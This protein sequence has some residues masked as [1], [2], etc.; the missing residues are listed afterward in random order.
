M[1]AS[2]LLP[3]RAVEVRYGTFAT[4]CGS[5]RCL[6]FAWLT[7]VETGAI[8]SRTRQKKNAKNRKWDRAAVAAGYHYLEA[9]E[10]GA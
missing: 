7:P 1:T 8:R 3:I 10:R 6:R 5:L 2:A 4:F 9:I